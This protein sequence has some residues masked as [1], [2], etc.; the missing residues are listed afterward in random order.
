MVLGCASPV[1]VVNYYVSPSGNDGSSGTSLATAWATVDHARSAIQSSLGAMTSNVAVNIAPGDYWSTAAA[2]TD[3]DS[4]TGNWT[5]YYQC[6]G[7]VGTARL[8]G[9]T[10]VS[11]AS[12]S[13]VAGSIYR[14][15]LAGPALTTMW[16]NGT[17]AYACRTPAFVADASYP[18]AKRP[19]LSSA[20]VHLS[21]TVL[22]YSPGDLS[23]GGF[24]LNSAQVAI[25]SGGGINWLEDILPIQSVNVGS[26]QLTL[27]QATFETIETGS[28]YFVQGH[29]LAALTG[30]G[31]F[32]HDTV[33]GFLY[34]WPMTAP[35]T[36]QQIVIPSTDKVLSL[37]GTD[38]SHRAK[39]IVF[40]GLAVA[41]TK[42][43]ST[44]QA[45]SAATTAANHVNGAV[46]LQNTQN[47]KLLN[48]NVYNTGLH[49]VCLHSANTQFRL[50]KTWIHNTGFYGLHPENN[51]NLS[52][53]TGD[54]LTN[55]VYT[56]FKVN[57]TGELVGHGS[58]IYSIN[59]SNSVWDHFE[60][61]NSPRAGM[62]M[63]GDTFNF[64]DRNIVQYGKLHALCQDSADMGAIYTAV[65]ADKA[66]TFNQITID[67]VNNGGG[68]GLNVRA[69]YTDIGGGNQTVSN[70]NVTNTSDMYLNNGAANTLTNVAWG[71]FDPTQMS[72]KI[73][74][75]SEFPY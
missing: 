53:N 70:V 50:E 1:P 47:V 72:S 46:F 62:E 37:I 66:N 61:Y 48:S 5:V 19:Y 28:R 29:A 43:V 10:V 11:P 9:G 39:N 4:G 49:G 59:Q 25:F 54:S 68:I 35:I 64:G 12:W 42:G 18:M 40:N 52:P 33:G 55:N 63:R 57:N 74:V 65:D 20:G 17:R 2:F 36:A 13:L 60:L 32:Y 3:A 6:S 56:N 15:S 75:T 31:Q 73:G 22:Q 51:S 58:C 26:L 24:D 30:P 71:T 38:T 16:E 45:D 44:L 34:Y 41:Y 67:N 8:N 14:M 27:T 69:F 23:P 21:Q 7:A